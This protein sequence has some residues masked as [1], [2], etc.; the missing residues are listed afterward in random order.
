MRVPDL[1]IASR[2]YGKWRT[3]KEW[4]V[5][6]LPR[7]IGVPQDGNM[8]ARAQTL[9]RMLDRAAAR[10]VKLPP[11]PMR[12]LLRVSAG[13]LQTEIASLVRDERHPNG[14]DRATIARYELGTREPREG[15]RRAYA[16]ILQ[17]L[18]GL[19]SK[20]TEDS[21]HA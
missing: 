7:A 16:T 20:T 18:S 13:L 8:P 2:E 1:A 3:C 10:G 21:S 15:L 19:H 12:R 14:V 11:P 6:L 17:S 9:E 5:P 4:L